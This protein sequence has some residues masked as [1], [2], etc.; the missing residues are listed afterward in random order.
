MLSISLKTVLLLVFTTAI[1]TSVWAC[2]KST[3][4]KE[5]QNT[6]LKCQKACC[7]K[8]QSN[9]KNNC[10]SVC[11]KKQSTDKQKEKKGCCGDEDCSCSASTTILADLPKPFILNFSSLEPVFICENDF[12]YKQVFTITSINAIWQP[13][14]SVL[15]L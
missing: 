9:V 3:S 10:Q 15:S 5:V 1:N 8:M 11:C 6:V 2:H 13:P 4:K 12:F 7:K 14:I